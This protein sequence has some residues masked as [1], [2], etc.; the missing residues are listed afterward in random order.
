MKK[1]LA[2]PFSFIY[3]ILFFTLLFVFHPIQ[4]VSLKLGGYN[5]HKKS[6][7]LLNWCLVKS[8]LILSVRVKFKNTYV[9]PKNTPIIFVSNHQSMNDIP[10]LIWFLREFHPKFVSKKELGNGIPSIS[11]N[12]K[13]GGSVLIDRN[14]GTAAL[15][16]I[17]KF[18]QF[19]EE[20]RYSAVIFPEGTRSRNGVPKRFSE[21]GLKMLVKTMPSAY[22]VPITINNS[23]KLHEFGKFPL[24]IG[25]SIH[26]QVHKPL[27]VSS[28][29]FVKLFNEVETVV[30]NAVV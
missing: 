9:I 10:P 28:K 29:E 16:A 3:W 11:F 2:I 8:L 19:I 23:W 25:F 13:H 18:G 4:W 12:L 14:D 1:L 15:K 5:A 27:K 26:F 22:V 7:D 30:V 20:K 24:G 6:V 17:L 21:N